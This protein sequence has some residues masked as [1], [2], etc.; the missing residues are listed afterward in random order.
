MRS[1]KPALEDRRVELESWL[2]E[3]RS[4]GSAAK[5]MPDAIRTFLEDFRDMDIRVQKAHLQTILKAA[6]VYREGRLELEFRG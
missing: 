3:Q 2:E 1:Q 6:H 4:R 5:R